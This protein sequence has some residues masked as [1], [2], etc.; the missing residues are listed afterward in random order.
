M[1]MSVSRTLLSACLLGAGLWA[2]GP[3]L[4]APES[5]EVSLSGAQQTK[6]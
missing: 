1:S 2:A 6:Q 4:A 5:F 3:C